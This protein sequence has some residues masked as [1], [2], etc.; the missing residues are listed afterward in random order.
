MPQDEYFEAE[1]KQRG[2]RAAQAK[3][4]PIPHERRVRWCQMQIDFP[5]VWFGTI[6]MIFSARAVQRDDYTN[7]TEWVKVA[8]DFEDAGFTPEQY[9]LLRMCIRACLRV[10]GEEVDHHLLYS[11]RG[12]RGGPKCRYIKAS[13]W[14]LWP[15]LVS[16]GMTPL[17]AA[18][19]ILDGGKQAIP[20]RMIINR[21]GQVIVSTDD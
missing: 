3:W 16:S 9:Y 1:A 17:R 13:D 11:H 4:D 2:L 20:D 18:G 6:P 12:S 19:L 8:H 5:P 21:E 14:V 10:R 7:I 15:E